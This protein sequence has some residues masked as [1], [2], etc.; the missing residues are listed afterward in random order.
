M[1]ALTYADIQMMRQAHL[2]QIGNVVDFGYYLMRRNI[3]R[4]WRPP[5]RPL[6]AA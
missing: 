3:H 5:R 4:F 6:G 2:R 1:A